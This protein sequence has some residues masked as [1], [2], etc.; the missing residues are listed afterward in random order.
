MPRLN[1]SRSGL[2]F[3]TKHRLLAAL[4]G[5]VTSA[6]GFANQDSHATD[7]TMTPPPSKRLTELTAPGAPQVYSGTELASIAMPVGGIYAGQLYFNGDGSLGHWDIMN[8]RAFGVTSRVRDSA[9]LQQGFAVRLRDGD[10]RLTSFPLNLKTFPATTF[11][12]AYPAGVVRYTG[13]ENLPVSI[14]LEGIA[15]FVPLDTAASDIPATFLRVTLKNTGGQTVEGD[16]LGWLQNGAA[17]FSGLRA[18]E[19]SRTATVRTPPGALAVEFAAVPSAT[20][21]AAVASAESSSS[22]VHSDNSENPGYLTGKFKDE[23]AVSSLPALTARPDF[24]TM[25]L[26]LLAPAAD[27]R[28]DASVQGDFAA[29]AAPVVV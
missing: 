2:L 4:L 27:A 13:A 8:R 11:T 25:A 6:A 14:T 28:A 10:G 29:G 12:A 9:K 19:G 1:A 24:G 26:V 3:A 23:A 20:A 7:S 21:L 15:P 17:H 5:V 16:V 18:E 22:P